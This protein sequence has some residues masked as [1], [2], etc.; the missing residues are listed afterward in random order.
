[1]A[2]R[3]MKTQQV[4]GICITASH[5]PAPDNGI[6]MVEPTGEMLQQ[7]YEPV[8]DELANAVSDQ[9][10]VHLV[11]DFMQKEGITI[12]QAQDTTAPTPT[13]PCTVLI[14]HDTRPSGPELAE[15]A[16]AGARCVGCAPH[17]LGLLTTPQ[18][19]WAVMRTNQGL[20]P[21]EED[22]YQ[23]LS[24]AFLKL[25]GKADPPYKLYVDCAN[26][27][28]GPKL[29]GMKAAL[30][31]SGLIL[32]LRNTGDGVLNKGC[33]SDFVQN[34]KTLPE[35]FSVDVYDGNDKAR[36]LRCC[37]VDGDA[38]RLVYFVPCAGDKKDMG[39]VT[40]LDGDKIAALAAALIKD[41]VSQLPGELKT[42]VSVGV[43]QT[44]YANGSSTKYLRETIACEVAVTPTGVKH[45]HEAAHAFDV[46]I[47]FEANGHGTV[48]FKKALLDTLR[49]IAEESSAAAELLA[50]DGVI[51]PAV[52][53]AISGILMVEAALRRRSWSLSQWSELYTDLPSKQVKVKV[54]DRSV[55]TTTDA[56]RRVAEPKALQDKIDAIVATVPGG[57]SF[58]RPSGTEDVVR[59]YAEADNV[60]DMERLAKEVTQA[61]FELA[62]GI[63]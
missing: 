52:G 13:P 54:A 45:L 49:S 30:Q 5:N 44:A 28:G 17:I 55:I 25:A 57:R 18:L 53:D 42:S 7:R 32:E 27:V 9:E 58:V 4:T 21:T 22:Y 63:A 20:G 31:L 60:D 37:A 41:L 29:E 2:I 36:P 38:D 34:T 16:A 6:K 39:A 47:Y 48:L 59:V 35:N 8:A 46:G 14:A 11:L 3:A 19:H 56:E 15:A 33:G 43:V 12:D 10:V 40:L 51:N 24:S 50:L 62:G 1:M 23:V 61:V 26:G